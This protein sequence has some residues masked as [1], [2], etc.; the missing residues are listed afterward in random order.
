MTT[1][2]ARARAL[3]QATAQGR[4]HARQLLSLDTAEDE[5]L[6]GIVIVAVAKDYMELQGRS[7]SAARL[8]LATTLLRRIVRGVIHDAARRRSFAGCEGC[9]A[10]FLGGTEAVLATEATVRHVMKAID[11]QAGMTQYAMGV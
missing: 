2:G 1:H 10:A 3:A 4:A 9:W 8:R 7:G 11:M 6:L 5:G